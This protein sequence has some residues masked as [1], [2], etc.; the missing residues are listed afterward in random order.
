M[1]P[2]PAAD[3]N[4]R[5]RIPRRTNCETTCF[6]IAVVPGPMAMSSK[7]ITTAKK[8]DGKPALVPMLLNQFMRSLSICLLTALLLTSSLQAAEPFWA[9][10]PLTP[11]TSVPSEVLDDYWNSQFLRVNREVAAAQNTQLVFFGDSLTWYW[12]L[13]NATGRE[14]WSDQFSSYNP[15]NMG[16]SGDI[17]PVMLHRVTRGNLD[18]APG[19]HPKV[20]VIL[21]GINNFGVTK[22][23]GGKETWDLGINCPPEDIAHGQRAIAQVFRRRLPQTRVIMM[24]LL[25]VAYQA[26]WEK[27]QRVNAINASL[28][29]D[30]NEVAYLNL[31]A[32][33]LQPDDT[34]NRAMYSDGLHLSKAGYQAWA[35][36]IAPV[37][38]KFMKAPP[39]APVKIMLIGGSV[40]EGLD[41]ST[42]YRRYLDGMMRRSGHLIDLV[43]SRHKHNDDKAEPD[44]YQFD[45]DHEGHRGKDS[46]WIAENMPR[47]L[48][49]NV[50]DVAVINLGAEDIA[51]SHAAAESLTDG[52]VENINRVIKSLQLKNGNVKIVI[53]TSILIKGK[54]ATTEMLNKKILLLADTTSPALKPAVV[55][56]LNQGFDSNQDM[57]K[58]NQLPTAS[59]AK[60]IA[61]KLTEAINPL[62]RLTPQQ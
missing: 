9:E 27:C 46:L 56:D 50:P 26:K 24:A 54:E 55:A 45:P 34:I 22:S 57:D 12:S 59:G 25:P 31:Q 21:C 39:L 62:L 42:S 61:T 36:G 37:I 18:F 19:Q 17:T 44:S 38:D 11:S 40:T 41:S 58:A 33:F 32:S 15:I 48:E 4:F 1:K 29:A 16:N 6:A 10:I 35:K 60:K 49:R 13:G 43:G 51:S 14:M 28:E 30:S 23:A 47:L 3:E 52:I 8:E 5:P 2:K 7:A 53:A 20:A